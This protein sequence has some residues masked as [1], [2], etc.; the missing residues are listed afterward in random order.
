MGLGASIITFTASSLIRSA[1]VNANFN[2][3]NNATAF[4]GGVPTMAFDSGKLLSDGNGNIQIQGGGL[5]KSVVGDMINSTASETD[6]KAT[7]AVVLQTQG[8]SIAQITTSGIQ[9]LSGGFFF[10]KGSISRISSF[11]GTGSGTYNHGLGTTPTL[12]ILM[13]T[14]TSGSGISPN[15]ASPTPTTIYIFANAHSFS[16]MAAVVT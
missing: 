16:A 12:A 9:M 8:L 11:S 15:F 14:A 6:L 10:Q 3:L 5:G 1:D 4:N 2:N 13:D 7:T